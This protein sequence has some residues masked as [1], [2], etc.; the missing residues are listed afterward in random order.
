MFYSKFIPKLNMKLAPLY[1][2]LQKGTKWEWDNE[3]SK[4]F[5]DCKWELMSEKILIHY[6]PNKQITVTCDVSN[7]GIAGVLNHKVN[8]GE[9]PL[10]GN[11]RV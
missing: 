6:D 11:T 2:L 5:N 9:R 3:C 10:R 7:D 4:T 1:R 8:G